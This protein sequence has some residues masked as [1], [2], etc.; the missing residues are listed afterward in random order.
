MQSKSSQ[1]RPEGSVA[2][3]KRDFIAGVSLQNFAELLRI[4]ILKNIYK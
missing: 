3:P 4:P 2:N 1:A